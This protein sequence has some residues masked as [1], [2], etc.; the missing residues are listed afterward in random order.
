MGTHLRAKAAA[1]AWGSAA[2]A[3]EV[4]NASTQTE[5]LKGDATVQTSDCRK[6][7][8]LSPVAGTGSRPACK[9]CATVED[10][11]QQVAELQE[12]M[13]RLCN[14]REAEKELHS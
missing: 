2:F 10:L 11:P 4:A 3:P 13:R 12:A 9:S 14:I 5:M 6:C 1:L 8:D 7:L